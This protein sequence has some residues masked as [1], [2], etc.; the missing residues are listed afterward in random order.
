MTAGMSRPVT[1]RL[2][3]L[4][5]VEQMLNHG[6]LFSMQCNF[7]CCHHWTCPTHPTNRNINLFTIGSICTTS[8][9][10]NSTSG[11]TITESAADGTKATKNVTSSVPVIGTTSY[12]N[13]VPPHITK[14]AASITKA[15]IRFTPF[16]YSPSTCRKFAKS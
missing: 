12:T 14:R 13:R 3:P 9:L 6:H 1:V 15:L 2:K 7:G 5:I 11:P 16:C 4:M 8:A 10:P